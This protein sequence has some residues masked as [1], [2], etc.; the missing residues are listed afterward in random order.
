M[1][2]LGKIIFAIKPFDMIFKLKFKKH[3]YKRLKKRNRIAALQYDSMAI[4][5]EHHMEET[6]IFECFNAS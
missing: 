6:G 3:G 2:G 1:V 4:T 5:L